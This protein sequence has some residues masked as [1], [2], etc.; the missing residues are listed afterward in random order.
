LRNNFQRRARRASRKRSVNWN[1][2]A[3]ID[4]QGPPDERD[5]ASLERHRGGRRNH[6]TAVILHS[7][8][9]RMFGLT[10]PQRTAANNPAGW[11][12]HLAHI[13]PKSKD[14]HRAQHHSWVRYQGIG[15]VHGRNGH[16]RRSS[17][18]GAIAKSCSLVSPV[19][20]AWP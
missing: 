11:V 8:L 14:V 20:A 10:T 4:R 17:R 16:A 6:P 13:L 18:R 15:P 2:E 12:G 5:N 19:V 3:A 7:H 9:K 1:A